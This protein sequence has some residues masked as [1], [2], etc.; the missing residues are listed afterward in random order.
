M[1]GH[2]DLDQVGF[3]G[4]M[5][6]MSDKHTKMAELYYLEG[7]RVVADMLINELEMQKEERKKKKRKIWTRNWIRKRQ[8][9]GASSNFL[10]EVAGEDKVTFKNH[11]RITAEQFEQ[12][13][14]SVKPKIQKVDTNMR[15]ALPARLKLQIALRYLASG[16]CFRTLECLYRVPKSSIS[17]FLPAVLEAIYESLEMYIQV[18]CMFFRLCIFCLC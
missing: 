18:S 7:V 13:L 17:K 8:A 16:C 2:V 10:T 4:K 6:W 12:L 9:L 5:T 11:L 15:A 14:E 1:L 3:H